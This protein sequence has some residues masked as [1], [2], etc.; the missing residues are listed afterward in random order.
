MKKIAAEL[1]YRTNLFLLAVLSLTGVSLPGQTLQSAAYNDGKISAYIKEDVKNQRIGYKNYRIR[2]DELII[3]NIFD[4]ELAVKYS[5]KSVALDQNN[6]VVDEKII[7]RDISLRAGRTRIESGGE[8][9]GAAGYC[10]DSFS[11][12]S[13]RVKSVSALQSILRP[14]RENSPSAKK[15][16]PAVPAW[17]QGVWY[18]SASR[19]GGKFAEI[20]SEAFIGGGTFECSR[21][22]GE[23]VWFGGEILITRANSPNQVFLGMRTKSGNTFVTLYR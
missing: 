1:R 23:S 5:F 12:T 2:A 9:R 8:S 14:N 10:V 19:T 6:N 13:V 21:A 4:G 18:L 17:A 20:T 22:E 16:T 7:Y 15:N 11:V 3:E